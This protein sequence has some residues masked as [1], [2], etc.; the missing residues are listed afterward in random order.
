MTESGI[1]RPS[2]WATVSLVTRREIT[3]RVR[4]RAFALG[5]L[6]NI[7][8]I[9]G[10]LFFF[11]PSRGEDVPAV[12]VT[13][14]SVLDLA[15]G[16]DR[17]HGPVDWRGA[18]TP[19][20]AR[21]QV[22]DKKVDA[23]LLVHDGRTRLVVRRDTPDQVRAAVSA[24]VQQWATGRALRAQHTDM[25]LLHRQVVRAQPVTQTLGGTAAGGTALGAAVGVV[26]VLFFQVFGYGMLVAQ[27]V[28]EEKSTR[29]V[30]VLLSTITPL[31]LMTGKVLGIGAAAL[32][33]ML[34][35]AA[36]VMGADQLW[37]ILP[38]GFPAAPALLAAVGW[39][40]LGF[41][42]F[43][44]LFAAAG[45]LVSR[46]EDVSATVMPVLMTTM[47]P[48][49]AAVAAVSDPTAAWV[50]VLRYVPPFSTLI[51]PLQ[52]SVGA[53]GWLPNVVAALFLLAAAAG[54]AAFASHVY[55]RSILRV[56]A[57]VRWRS[58]LFTSGRAGVAPTP[59]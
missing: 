13:G 29:V 55:E 3:A 24:A 37:G 12:A 4:T 33:Q 1:R 41:V 39:F 28:V 9:L 48:Y 46:A 16:G 35:F 59:D 17:A 8:A 40:V 44:F 22:A 42:F 38:G 18:S 50:N 10:L 5:T 54:L 20:A 49:G 31:R 45:S 11:G 36:A 26:T 56:G 14:A 52:V 43:A 7:A 2:W 34:L 21:R 19:G 27:G 25:T 6:A 32:L 51:M 53:A 47:V 15:P 23:A 57:A 58:A 30:E